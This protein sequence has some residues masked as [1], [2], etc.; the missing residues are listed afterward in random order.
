LVP[1]TSVH[2]VPSELFVLLFQL[3][4]AIPVAISDNNRKLVEKSRMQLWLK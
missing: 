4:T 1:G 2:F 3:V